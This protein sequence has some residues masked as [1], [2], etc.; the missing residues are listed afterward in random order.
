MNMHRPIFPCSIKSIFCVARNVDWKPLSIALMLVLLQE[1]LWAVSRWSSSRMLP[2]RRQR[3]FAN[4]VLERP[5]MRKADLKATK[6]AN[7]TES[8]VAYVTPCFE[9]AQKEV[10]LR[11]LLD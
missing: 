1:N 4:I 5:R 10:F 6:V 3:T 2:Q 11:V 9:R 8:L 7:F